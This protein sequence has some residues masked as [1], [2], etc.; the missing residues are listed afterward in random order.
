MQVEK[1]RPALTEEINKFLGIK[2]NSLSRLLY[3]NA[4]LSK[5][6]LSL[7]SKS[8][9][10]PFTQLRDEKENPE[11]S[12]L[13]ESEKEQIR[14]IIEK[15]LSPEETEV[16]RLRF[17]L[18]C[19]DEPVSVKDIGKRLGYKPKAVYFIQYRAFRKLRESG[20]YSRILEGILRGQ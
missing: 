2:P 6:T 16:I 20:R 8:Q 17:G 18:N 4:Y 19:L 7:S 14:S 12:I 9:E 5:G 1:G 10:Y 3:I 11:K 15:I 13:E